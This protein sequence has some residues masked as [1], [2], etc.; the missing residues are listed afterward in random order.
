MYAD[1]PE[2]KEVKEEEPQAEEQAA[3]EEEEEEPEDVSSRLRITR[4]ETCTHCRICPT[5]FA[6]TARRMQAICKVCRCHATFRSLPGK[7]FRW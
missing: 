3:E 1:A 7:S 6:R 5:G 2:E 4:L